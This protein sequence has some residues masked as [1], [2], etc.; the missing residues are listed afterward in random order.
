MSNQTTRLRP[1]PILGFPLPVIP[2]RLQVVAFVLPP[3]LTLSE[4]QGNS[5]EAEVVALAEKFVL[6]Q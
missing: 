1:Q 5:E 2:S 4:L 3:R 6:G